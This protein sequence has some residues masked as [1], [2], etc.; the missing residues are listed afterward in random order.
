VKLEK[1]YKMAREYLMRVWMQDYVSRILSVNNAVAADATEALF[2]FAKM[3]GPAWRLDEFGA[4]I[5][6]PLAH[7]LA[8]DWQGRDSIT[9]FSGVAKQIGIPSLE[10]ISWLQVNG[11]DDSYVDVLGEI[12]GKTYSTASEGVERKGRS[13]WMACT[14]TYNVLHEYFPRNRPVTS[15]EMRVIHPVVYNAK[16]LA[17]NAW[18]AR[19]QY[20]SDVARDQINDECQAIVR[21]FDSILL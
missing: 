8:S 17:E 3:G 2:E 14:A 10:Y 6:L 4:R 21:E 18:G 13:I 9:A 7:A 19:F 16:F 12:L 20:I 11:L 5:L 1:E 15:Q